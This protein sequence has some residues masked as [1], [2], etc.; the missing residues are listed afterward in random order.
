MSHT[1]ERVRPRRVARSYAR[2]MLEPP[3]VDCHRA[4]EPLAQRL[5]G[6]HRRPPSARSSSAFVIFE[7]PR[8]C[9]ASPPRRAGRAFFRAGSCG[10][11]GCRPGGPTR[12]P[13][14]RALTTLR[15]SPLLARSLFT[16]RAAIS[17]AL[18]SDPPR[19]QLRLLDV[20]VLARLFVPFLHTAW[21]HRR[22]S[23]GSR[24]IPADPH[25]RV[26][27]RKRDVSVRRPGGIPVGS[28]EGGEM[29]FGGRALR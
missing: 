9:A 7:R 18:S 23:F 17:S 13:R 22:S 12:C 16:V 25:T 1:G 8:C 20:L 29:Y 14:A 2:A 26:P 5:W 27:R 3:A 15:A 24:W 21:R 10:G 4:A 28:I 11:C 6:S 19:S